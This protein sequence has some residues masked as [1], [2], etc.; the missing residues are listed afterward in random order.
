M[1]AS[2]VV[3]LF[4]P[5]NRFYAPF[6]IVTPPGFEFCAR[7]AGAGV[8]L[9]EHLRKWRQS[10]GGAPFVNRR[11]IF[12]FPRLPIARFVLHELRAINLGFGLI[13]AD[14]VQQIGGMLRRNITARN[15]FFEKTQAGALEGRIADRVLRNSPRCKRALLAG[16][17]CSEIISF[18]RAA[19]C[20]WIPSIRG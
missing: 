6:L 2:G 20:L 16:Q 11:H 4:R 1:S 17:P 5:S 10:D 18:R 15:S 19:F 8:R 3:C 12:D 14:T 9:V 13:H 7:R